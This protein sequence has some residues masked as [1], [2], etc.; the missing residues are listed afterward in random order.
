LKNMSVPI[1]PVSFQEAVEARYKEIMLL[2]EAGCLDE[3]RGEL[4]S[5]LTD[6]ETETGE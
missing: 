6:I 1:M 3:A 5:L 4:D 2:R